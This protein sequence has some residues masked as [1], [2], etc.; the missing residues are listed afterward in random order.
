MGGPDDKPSDRVVSQRV[1]DRIIE[2]LELV[3]SFDAQVAYQ[4]RAPSVNVPTEVI[5]Q[6]EDRYNA[7]RP[8]WCSP[9]VYTK[10]EARALANSHAEL[11]AVCDETGDLN[12]PIE[13]VVQFP[14]WSRLRDEA[15]S[16]LSVLSRRGRFSEDVEDPRAESSVVTPRPDP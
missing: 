11:I 5:N 2:Y 3:S 14:A 8:E 15:R 13:E 4:R 7:D 12:E 6:W 16:A 1:R 9:P 10:A